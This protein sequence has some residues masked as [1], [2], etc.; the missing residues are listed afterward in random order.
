VKAA[1]I[2]ARNTTRL[3]I[4]LAPIADLHYIDGPL[5]KGEESKTDRP[6]PWWLKGEAEDRWDDTV[7]GSPFS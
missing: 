5:L 6:R 4:E 2:I 3:F 1:T 7:G